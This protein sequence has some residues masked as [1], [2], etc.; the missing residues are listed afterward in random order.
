MPPLRGE[1]PA[2]L[3]KQV[4]GWNVSQEHHITRTLFSN[5]SSKAF[6]RESQFS[7]GGPMMLPR[8]TLPG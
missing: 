5:R 8:G 2:A 6:A 3:Q 7:V 4:E 1:E